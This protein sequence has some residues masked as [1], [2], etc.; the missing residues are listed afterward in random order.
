[1]IQR[2]E[3]DAGRKAHIVRYAITK[4]LKNIVQ[5][6][7]SIFERVY[8]IKEKLALRMLKTGY[9]QP[10]RFGHWCPVQV[11]IYKFILS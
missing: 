8:P 1:M 3:L 6:R 2:I 4:K 7:D 5:H 9:K 10:S 11:C